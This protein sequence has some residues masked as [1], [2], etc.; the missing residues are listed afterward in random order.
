[1]LDFTLG[2]NTLGVTAQNA[3]PS[4]PIGY[5]YFKI[6]FMDKSFPPQF[7]SA[8]SVVSVVKSLMQPDRL[9]DDVYHPVQ[10]VLATGAFFII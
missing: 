1:V 10:G 9:D 8:F 7:F 4:L 2:K 6:S 5:Y 3:Q